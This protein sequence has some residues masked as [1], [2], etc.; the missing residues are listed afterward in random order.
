MPC[1]WQLVGAQGEIAQL[2][3]TVAGLRESLELAQID[4][5]NAIS[6]ERALAA[7]EVTQLQGTIQNLRDQIDSTRHSS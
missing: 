5:T 2:R 3:Q 1:A 4:K 6:R 7:D